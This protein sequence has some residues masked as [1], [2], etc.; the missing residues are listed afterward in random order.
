MAAGSTYLALAALPVL[1]SGALSRS[2]RRRAAQASVALGLAAGAALALST[3]AEPVGL[4]QRAGITLVDVW[5][6]ASALAIIRPLRSGRRAG[7]G[8]A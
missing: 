8:G 1:A 6:V 2:G 5:I 3:V 7:P 4:F